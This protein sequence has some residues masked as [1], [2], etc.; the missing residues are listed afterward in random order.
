MTFPFDVNHIAVSRYQHLGEGI[1]YGE[2][3]RMKTTLTGVMT[4]ILDK[5]D[6]RIY[7]LFSDLEPPIRRKIERAIAE[8]VP[9]VTASPASSTNQTVSVLMEQANAAIDNNDFIKAKALLSAVRTMAPRDGYV[10]QRLALATYKAEVPDA[11]SALRDARA[12][13]SDLDPTSCTDTETLGLWA[14]IHKRLYDVTK[15]SQD[16]NIA[17]TSLEKGFYLKNDEYN[18]INLAFLYDLRS[19]VTSGE[20]SEADSILARRIRRRVLDICTR[21]LQ[22]S[23]SLHGKAALLDFGNYGASIRGAWRR[24]KRRASIGR[25]KCFE[26]GRL[27]G[28]KH[29]SAD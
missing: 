2:V 23:Q 29:R 21:L 12:V 8:S 16:L 18:G 4:A 24:A 15:E 14:A 26:A 3:E 20:E 22:H 28:R 13:V 1:D 10:A 19:S 7:T 25:R 9:S 11:V 17:I 6:S 5:P 27:D